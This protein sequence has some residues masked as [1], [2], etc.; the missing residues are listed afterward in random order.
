[1]TYPFYKL[2]VTDVDGTLV[3]NN[4]EISSENQNALNNVRSRGIQIAISTGRPPKSSLNIIKKLP[5]S[6]YHIFFDGALV[7][8]YR[9]GK[10]AYNQT[11]DQDLVKQLVFS[12][13][14]KDI[15]LEL[16][17]KYACFAAIENWWTEA[18]RNV[19]GI[20][21]HI[22]NLDDIW[23]SEKIMKGVLVIMN[24]DEKDFVNDFCRH[25][26]GKLEFR[27]VQSPP[28]SEVTFINV[29]SKGVSKGK[30]LEVLA[31]QLC[32]K[33][34]EVVAIGDWINDIPLLTTA[35][36]GIAMGNAHDD[37]KKIADF[38]TLT[39]E[40]NGLAMAIKKF[41]L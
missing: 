28:Y 26:A 29:L 24:A 11:I 18:N 40:E 33:L 13:R 20:D 39:A 4:G 16:Y 8:N 2:L 6:N 10:V 35:G 37:L 34:E 27:E 23:L 22:Q 32:I 15:F 3:N 38:V 25:Y 12:A 41:L 21:T 30:A 14:E 5:L 1:M 36:L 9:T 7:S 19:Y 31:K 17:S